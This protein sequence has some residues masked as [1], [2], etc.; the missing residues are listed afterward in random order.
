MRGGIRQDY[1]QAVNSSKVP[2]HLSP[3]SP[4]EFGVAWSSLNVGSWPEAIVRRWGTE[5]NT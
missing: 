2:G 5:A 4:H 1:P 3:G